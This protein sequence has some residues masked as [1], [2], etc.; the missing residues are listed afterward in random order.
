MQYRLRTL[1]ILLAVLPPVLAGAWW[2][3]ETMAPKPNPWYYNYDGADINYR[4]PGP[5]FKLDREA[6]RRKAIEAAARHQLDSP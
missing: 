6:V 3:R 2:A 4:A 5:E 1:L